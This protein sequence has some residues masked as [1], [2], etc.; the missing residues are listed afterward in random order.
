[1]KNL[2]LLLIIS[3]A[4]FGCKVE[5]KTPI[6]KGEPAQI[7]QQPLKMAVYDGLELSGY[8]GINWYRLLTG[9]VIHARNNF[10]SSNQTGSPILYEIN[11]MGAIVS[12]HNL[13]ILPDKILKA[14]GGDIYICE[15]IPPEDAFAQGGLNRDYVQIWKN[16]IRVGHWSTNQWKC[17]DIVET[18]SG[19]VLAITS[20]GAHHGLNNSLSVQYAEHGGLLIHTVDIPARTGF[21]KTNFDYPESWGTN[22]ATSSNS[23]T[24]MK[25][26]NGWYNANGYSW[27]ESWGLRESQTVMRDWNNPIPEMPVLLSAG[28]SLE[29]GETVLY[30][31]ECNTGWLYRYTPSVDRMDQVVRLYIGDGLRASGNSAKAYL[32]SYIVGGIVYFNYGG[33]LNKADLSNGALSVFVGTNVESWKW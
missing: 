28:T 29:A 23:T 33:R 10:Y 24:W 8:D 21:Y 30:W 2:L 14:E 31:L 16:G 7:T 1:M 20:L 18:E 13:P 4:V 15:N 22:Y 19:D 17:S 27:S 5:N 12:E 25:S 3:L 6:N 26:G 32:K 9:N 11:S